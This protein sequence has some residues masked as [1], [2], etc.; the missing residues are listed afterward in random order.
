MELDYMEISGCYAKSL[1]LIAGIPS[2]S[3]LH[4]LPP[5]PVPHLCL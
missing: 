3:S 4:F 2:P 1:V 5:L